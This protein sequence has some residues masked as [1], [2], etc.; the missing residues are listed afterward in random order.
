MAKYIVLHTLVDMPD[1]SYRNGQVIEDTFEHPNWERHD[2]KAR[3]NIFKRL[4]LLGSL[5]ELSEEAAA[6]LP[7]SSPAGAAMPLMEVAPEMANRPVRPGTTTNEGVAV[8]A[9]DMSTWEEPV[10]QSPDAEPRRGPGRPPKAAASSDH[11]FG[12]PSRDA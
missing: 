2:D 6:G 10:A 11:V 4:V 8:A 9:T 1:G 3:E 12:A 7:A 5:Q